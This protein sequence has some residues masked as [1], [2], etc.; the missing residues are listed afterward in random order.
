[1]RGELDDEGRL[2]GM[3]WVLDKKFDVISDFGDG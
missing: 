3:D 1:V 2:E